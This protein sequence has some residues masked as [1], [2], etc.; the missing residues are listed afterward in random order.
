MASNLACV[1]L[2]VADEEAFAALVESVIPE[3][4]TLGSR[5]GS[6]VLRWEDRS[7]ARL[8]VTRRRNEIVS[9]LP[10]FAG[11]PGA[12][13]SNV[14]PIG[15][16][17]VSIDV[18]EDDELATRAGIDLE[19]RPLLRRGVGGLASIVALGVDVRVFSDAKTFAQ[20]D[21]SLLGEPTD[22]P[23]PDHY[24]EAGLEWPPR[25]G[26]ESFVSHG[27]FATDEPPTAYAWLSGTVLGASGQLVE[28]TGQ[29]FVSVR[30]RTVGFEA[31]VCL[32][33]PE[34]PEVPTAG[35]VVAG[36]VYLVGSLETAAQAER[37]S[38]R[39]F[40]RA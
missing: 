10:S 9:V 30:V 17:L 34:H 21:A 11:T 39:W 12:R 29:R 37:A 38:R 5:R 1:G 32:P 19:Q 20:S 3:A 14:E 26:A 8:V 31:D 25:F 40:R 6:T 28:R 4:E 33:E 36:T 18:V 27:L 13:I 2:D 23:A 24:A 15:D 16:E 7:G 22:E 35:Q